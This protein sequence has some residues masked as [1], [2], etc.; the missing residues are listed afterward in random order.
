[1]NKDSLIFLELQIVIA[2]GWCFFF[3]LNETL[4][5]I[6]PYKD[7]ISLLFLP[8]G[9]KIVLACLL[10]WQCF[11]GLF[12]GSIITGL[13]Y[14]DYNLTQHLWFFSL[15]SAFSPVVTVI[16][17]D[18]FFNLGFKLSEISLQKIILIAALYAF[19]CTALHNTYL[20][21]LGEISFIEFQQDS[22]AMF[23]GDITGA[24]L[25]L[26]ILSYYRFP[27]IKLANRYL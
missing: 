24:M 9:Y 5:L 16:I 18:Y 13:I 27:L 26:S 22:L 6:G 8:A 3:S 14:L 12:I 7:Y 11:L 15:F 4:N 23:I 10:K 20:L 17:I 1:M 21:M 2:L 25:F 19:I